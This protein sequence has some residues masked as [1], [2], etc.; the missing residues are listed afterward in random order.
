MVGEAIRELNDEDGNVIEIVFCN[1]SECVHNMGHGKCRIVHSANGD[2]K[3][4]LTHGACDN[5]LSS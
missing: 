4:S 5:Y 1:S 2:D 3:I